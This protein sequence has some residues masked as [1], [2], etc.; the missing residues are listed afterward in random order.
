MFDD[1]E[2]PVNGLEYSESASIYIAQLNNSNNP[3]ILYN[4][5]DSHTN[6]TGEPI[7]LEP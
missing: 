7:I 1:T 5:L 4:Q 3:T 6:S 2:Y